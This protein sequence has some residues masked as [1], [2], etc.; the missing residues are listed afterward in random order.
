MPSDTFNKIIDP[1]IIIL[2]Y[3]ALFLTTFVIARLIINVIS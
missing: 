2:A 1:V 3:E